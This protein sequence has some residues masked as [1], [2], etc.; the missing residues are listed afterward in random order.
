MSRFM[1]IIHC[2]SQPNRL[3]V[4]TISSQLDHL[5]QAM[6]NQPSFN[7][8]AATFHHDRVLGILDQCVSNFSIYF[9]V[10]KFC[11]QIW[12]QIKL[13]CRRGGSRLDVKAIDRLLFKRAINFKFYVVFLHIKFNFNLSLTFLRQ[14]GRLYEN[15]I[16]F[17]I[18]HNEILQI[19]INILI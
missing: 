8:S 6:A 1:N 17:I 7:E 5:R 19:F 10:R 3:S 9:L 16:H 11:I 13:A 2:Q 12:W 14:Q 15:L 18:D 4:I